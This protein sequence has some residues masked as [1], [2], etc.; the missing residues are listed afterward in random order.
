MKE[1]V[2]QHKFQ[3]RRPASVDRPHANPGPP[4]VYKPLGSALDSALQTGKAVCA[5]TARRAGWGFVSPFFP[6]KTKPFCAKV[7]PQGKCSGALQRGKGI[8]GV[9]GRLLK[10]CIII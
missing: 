4:E 9:Y 5:L 8:S 7:G 1:A 6:P 3:A 2:K 10:K